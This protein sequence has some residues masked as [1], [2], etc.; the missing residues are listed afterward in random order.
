MNQQQLEL[1]ALIDQQRSKLGSAQ[2]ELSRLKLLCKH[3]IIKEGLDDPDAV[4]EVC[5]TKFGWWCPDSP[6]HA[7]HYYSYHDK[8][9]RVVLLIDETDYII[10]EKTSPLPDNEDSN[11]CLFCGEPEERK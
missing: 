6:D 4:C 1:K 8:G 10:P 11:F 2:S 5:G 7:C 3:S 9:K